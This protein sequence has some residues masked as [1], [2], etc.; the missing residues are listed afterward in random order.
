MLGGGPSAYGVAPYR[1]LVNT[2]GP[3]ETNIEAVGDHTATA[4]GTQA[5]SEVRS[6]RIDLRGIARRLAI[7]LLLVSP[8]SS[9]S[10]DAVAPAER[11]ATLVEFNGPIG[12]AISRYV[13]HS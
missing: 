12:P 8:V 3:L 13:E 1:N 7:G 5:V 2:A 9:L 11:F 4:Q 6:R 10:T